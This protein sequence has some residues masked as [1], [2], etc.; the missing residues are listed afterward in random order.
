[1]VECR[2][3]PRRPYDSDDDAPCARLICTKFGFG[4]TVVDIIT[5][6][7]IFGDRLMHDDSVGVENQ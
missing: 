5:R 7:K 6:A 4:V 1:M 3:G 2:Y